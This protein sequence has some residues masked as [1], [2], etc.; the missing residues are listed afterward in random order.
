MM[1]W[2]GW[3]LLGLFFLLAEMLTPGG[4]YLIFFGAGAL[5]VGTLAGLKFTGPEWTE[6]LLFSVFS[7]GAL[8]FFRKPLLKRFQTANMGKEI[9]SL[10]GEAAV[11]LDKIAVDAMGKV[12]LRGAAWNARNIGESPVARGQRC[13]VVQVDGLTLSVR[14]E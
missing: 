4:F 5:I 12:E 14:S 2:W 3:L 7:I 8:L 1:P 13:K 10:V 6:W 11:A 9:D